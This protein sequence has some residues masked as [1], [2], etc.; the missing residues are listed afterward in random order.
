MKTLMKGIEE[1]KWR[2]ILCSGIAKINVKMSMLREVLHRFQV[3]P[4]KIP[5]LFF[6]EIDNPKTHRKPQKN[7]M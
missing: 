7:Q 1:H 2:G 5:M 6:R 4:I 3:I